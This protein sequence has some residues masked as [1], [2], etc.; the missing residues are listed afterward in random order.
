M[1]I[2]AAGWSVEPPIRRP[3][4]RGVAALSWLVCAVTLLAGCTGGEP[5]GKAVSPSRGG[6]PLVIWANAAEADAIRPFVERFGRAHGVPVEVTAAPSGMPADY[7]AA[8]K[9]RR[10]PDIFA[11]LHEWIGP[12]TK[13]GAIEPVRLSS[14]QKRAF[15]SAAVDAV[16]YDGTGYGVPFGIENVALVRNTFLVPDTPRT[17]EETVAIGAQL[18]RAGKVAEPLSYPVGESGDAF[19]LY[20]LYASAGG[21]LFGEKSGDELDLKDL[22]IAKPAGSDAFAKIASL[23]V[24]GSG[25]LKPAT[26]IEDA[27]TAFAAGNSPFLVAGP[28]ALPRLRRSGLDYEI[29]QV[30]PF[31]EGK[32]T[33]PM[34]RVSAFFLNRASTNKSLARQLL[35]SLLTR[36]DVALALY[37]AQCR[38]PALA[39][40]L[41]RAKRST[42]DI[43]EFFDTGRGGVLVPSAPEMARVWAPFGQAEVAVL[44]GADVATTVHAAAKAIVGG[45]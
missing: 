43:K 17:I 3:V 21:Y 31:N 22:G 35:T 12:L 39:A 37:A 5:T 44:S 20:P 32:P 11:G 40:G 33:G 8:A 7:L 38:P 1:G 16:T 15:V 18:K 36:V 30:P 2:R 9:A 25:A 42:P 24:K 14:R 10:G 13:E 28:G 6:G 45:S 23:G 4:S 27:V 34:I 19:H 26:D 29:T 41:D